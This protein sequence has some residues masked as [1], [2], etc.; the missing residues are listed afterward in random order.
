[1][2]LAKAIEMLVKEYERAKHIEYVQKPLAWALFQVWKQA[3][4]E[5]K[6][7]GERDNDG[8]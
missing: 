1:M 5:E 6:K 2:T 8:I 7:K 3:D 4:K